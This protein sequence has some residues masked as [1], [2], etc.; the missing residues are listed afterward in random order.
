VILA[1]KEIRHG[2]FAN[3]I[4]L[5]SSAFSLI[6]N[7]HGLPSFDSM[8][9]ISEELDMDVRKIWLRVKNESID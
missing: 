3:K 7:N 9:K 8:Y 1:E 2:D 5:S 6:V 4:G